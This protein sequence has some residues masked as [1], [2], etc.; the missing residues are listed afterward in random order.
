MSYCTHRNHSCGKCLVCYSR[1]AANTSLTNFKCTH[2]I[3]F[4]FVP[5]LLHYLIYSYISKKTEISI[6]MCK[7]VNS[8]LYM[9]I[10]QRNCGSKLS[11]KSGFIL[12]FKLRLKVKLIWALVWNCISC[13]WPVLLVRHWILM[14]QLTSRQA[15]YSSC[16]SDIISTH[17]NIDRRTDRQTDRH[18]AS[19]TLLV[20]KY[21]RAL[22]STVTQRFIHT[23]P[24]LLILLFSLEQQ[25]NHS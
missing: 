8:L 15:S 13:M 2:N 5:S 17:H 19:E 25:Y 14:Q 22:V 10:Y 16:I 23:E 7:F 6:V 18:A 20:A 12:Q 4:A 1:V 21:L 24:S 9:A 3:S 11:L